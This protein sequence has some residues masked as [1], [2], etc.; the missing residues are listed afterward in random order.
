MDINN[1]KNLIIFTSS[2]PYDIAKEDSFLKIELECLNKRFGQITLVPSR[3]GG[4]IHK[5]P[6]EIIIIDDFHKHFKNNFTAKIVSLIYALLSK[7]F[8]VE[9][10]EKR[11]FLLKGNALKR[12]ILFH[13]DSTKTFK[14]LKTYI[15]KNKINVKNTIFYTYWFD[16]KT[17]GIC[18]LKEKQYPTMDLISRAHGIDLYEERQSPAFLPSRKYLLNLINGLFLACS[19]SANY[20]S[21]K[22]PEF[23]N[24]F[25]VF[26]LGIRPPEKL[27]QSSQDNIF[28]IV[29]CSS[30]IAVKRLDLLVDGLKELG[31]RCKNQQFEWHHI[32]GGALEEDIKRKSNYEL[33][34]NV[35]PIFH[36]EIPNKEVIKLYIKS[37]FDLFIIVSSSEGGVPLALQEAMAASIPVI[38]TDVGGIKDLVDEKNGFLL[39]ANPSPAAITQSIIDFMSL[40]EDRKKLKKKSAVSKCM[41]LCNADINFNAF[42]KKISEIFN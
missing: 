24:K 40:P 28:R 29:S 12:L 13:G 25:H 23:K 8:Y 4:I 3:K 21:A 37:Q 2:Y 16:A 20:I 30:I 41:E 14:W 31:N 38:G 35:K 7:K 26:R 9:I 17:H 34:S 22:Y 19:C 10:F 32:G 36:G 18:K 1:K 33:P 15:L 42:S 11:S 39:S 27:T 6:Q 5:T